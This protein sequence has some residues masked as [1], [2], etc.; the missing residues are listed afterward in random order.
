MRVVLFGAMIAVILFGA[1][2]PA[3]AEVRIALLI[4]NQS[5]NDKVGPLKNPHNDITL[6]DE[7]L[8]KLGF[9][10]TLVKD[11]GYK[12]IDTAIK[13][14]IQSVRREGQG[15]VG[16]VY[17][18]GHGAADPD[19]NLN[20]LIPVDVANADDDDLWTTSRT[21]K[22]FVESLRAQASEATHYVLFVACRNELKLTRK[23]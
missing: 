3:D 21:L 19:T 20:Y 22:G 23:G 14:H 6:I 2:A 7:A 16:L 8:Q 12:E 17:Y 15:A 1:P 4:G 5:Y 11:A 9:K 10:T 18:S 13:R